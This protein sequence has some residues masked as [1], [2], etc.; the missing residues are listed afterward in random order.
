[1]IDKVRLL[2]KGQLPQ[3]YTANVLGTRL[4]LDGRFLSFTELNA[5]ALRQVILSNRTDDEVLAWVQEHARPTTALEKHTWAEQIHRYRPDATLVEYRKRVYP[6][7]AAQVDVSSL[8]VLD[9]TDMD[10]GRLPVKG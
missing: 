1:M 5:E 9:L 3:T 7:L 4:T 8:S 6:E 2:A 10:E